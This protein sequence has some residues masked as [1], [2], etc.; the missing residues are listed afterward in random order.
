[1]IIA[2]ILYGVIFYLVIRLAVGHA[3]DH[4]EV[5]RII[6]ENEERRRAE[7]IMQKQ[8]FLS[9]EEKIKQEQRIKKLDEE[10]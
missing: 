4:S 8:L 9:E 6:I 10:L 2:I 3:I 1:M 7:E 5:G